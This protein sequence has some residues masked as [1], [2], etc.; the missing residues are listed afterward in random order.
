[1]SGEVA[2]NESLPVQVLLAMI[3]NRREQIQHLLDLAGRFP[4]SEYR[5]T[6]ETLARLVTEAEVLGDA[7]EQLRLAEAS[8]T[9][10]QAKYA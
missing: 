4:P 3:Q 6:V 8:G 7:V 5:H 2:A 9:T 1:M 10:A